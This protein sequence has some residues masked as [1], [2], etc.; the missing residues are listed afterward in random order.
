MPEIDGMELARRIQSLEI[1]T[2]PRLLLASAYGAHLP[3]QSVMDAGFCG[4]IAKPVALMHLRE[5]LLDALQPINSDT[6]THPKA[7]GFLHPDINKFS[8]SLHLGRK[9]LVAEDNLLNQEVAAQ[10]LLDIGLE[11]LIA[12]DG[13]EALRLLKGRNDI[14]LV[15][16]DVHMP[17]MDGIESTKSIR[18]MDEWRN[19]P[20]IAM[21][22][23]VLDE[24]RQSCADAGMN[25][26]IPKP[27]DPDQFYAVLWEWLPRE[28]APPPMPTP[29]AQALA[30]SAQVLDDAV[31]ISHWSRV[32]GLRVDAGL[33][34]VRGNLGTYGRL[35][36]RFVESHGSDAQRLRQAASDGAWENVN[37]TAHVLKSTAGSI[38]AL[39]LASTATEIQALGEAATDQ[40]RERL[41]LQLAQDVEL[42]HKDLERALHQLPQLPGPRDQGMVCSE[43]QSALQAELVKYL[44]DRDMAAVRFVREHETCLRENMGDM[45][46]TLIEAVRSFDYDTALQVVTQNAIP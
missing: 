25:G 41:A 5:Q 8:W 21:T 27:V 24:D 43:N 38:G 29:S 20:I 40:Q 12:N 34:T 3:T 35:I 30:S 19:L 28:Q 14:A 45:A 18:Q 4:V 16:M 39:Q 46:S 10:L 15:L 31:L 1:N 32:M 11:P 26:F 44:H 17:W 42:L 2:P 23:S 37:S 6:L 22:A 13:F 33:K 9:I 36:T 7:S